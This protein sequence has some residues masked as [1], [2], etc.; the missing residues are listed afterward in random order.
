MSCVGREVEN[1]TKE[2]GTSMFCI[3]HPE[4]LL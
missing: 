4:M 3:I 1:V 2:M